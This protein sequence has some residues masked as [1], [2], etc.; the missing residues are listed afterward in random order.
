MPNTTKLAEETG[1]EP[2]WPVKDRPLSKRV[3]DQ[4]LNSSK[5]AER[6]RFE[7]NA[8]TSTIGLAGRDD[9]PSRLHAP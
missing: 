2:A 5:M 1:F 4:L 8:L 3:S 9:T 7:L 6:L